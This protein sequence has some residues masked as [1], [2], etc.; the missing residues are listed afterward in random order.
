MTKLEKMIWH[1][2][3]VAF[4]VMKSKT[5][6]LPG[7]QGLPLYDVA[8]FF[9]KQVRKVGLNERAAAISFNLIMALPAALLFL[10][11]LIP[12]FP[13]APRMQREILNLFHDISPNTGTYTLISNLVSDLLDTGHAG[14]FSFGFLALIYYASNA[15]MGVIRTFDKSIHEPK[16]K[17][18]FQ[19]RVRAIRLTFILIV[20]VMISTFALLLGREQLV[21]VLKN[22]FD[23]KSRQQRVPWWNGLRWTIILALLYYGIALIYKYAPSLKKR[24]KLTSP[25]TILATTLTLATIILFSYWV[26]NFSSYNKVYGS[27]GTVIIIMVLVYINSLI[28]LIGFELNVSIVYLTREAEER[29]RKEKMALAVNSQQPTANS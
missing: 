16:R 3:P 10:F 19:K 1:S 6:V 17:Y 25:G 15:M 26:N 12:Y 29:M 2:A 22:F 20:L 11:S 9:V 14:V 27:I 5:I 7:F 13:N 4:L 28:L 8:V 18:I 21:F 24:W 23:M